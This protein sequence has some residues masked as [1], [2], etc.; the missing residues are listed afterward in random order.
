M[1]SSY[2]DWIL[3]YASYDEGIMFTPFIMREHFV[4]QIW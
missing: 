3:M 1:Y 2:D 4:R